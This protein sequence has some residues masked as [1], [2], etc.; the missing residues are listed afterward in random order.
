MEDEQKK[1]RPKS[2]SAKFAE[3]P[4][5]FVSLPNS[6]IVHRFWN[7]SLFN[8]VYLK[9]DL[10]ERYKEI[11]QV[12]YAPLQEFCQGFLNLC[13]AKESEDFTTWSETDTITNWVKPIMRLLGWQPD[14]NQNPFL[15]EVSFTVEERGEKKTYRLDILY[16]NDAKEKKYISGEKDPHKRLIEARHAGILP[17]EAKYWDRLEEYRQGKAESKKRIEHK[18]G[19]SLRALSPEGQ[20]LR[21]MQL[22]DKDYGILTDGRTW[23]LFHKNASDEQN[24]RC[25]EFNL[26]NL[27]SYIQNDIEDPNKLRTFIEAAKYFYFFFSKESLY[28]ARNEEPVVNEVLRYSQ[29]YIDHAEEDLRTRFIQAMNVACNGFARSAKEGGGTTDLSL[30]RSASESTLFNVLFLKHCEVRHV[31]PLRSVDYRKISL[32]TLIDRLDHLIFDPEKEDSINEEKLR[33]AFRSDFPYSNAGYEVYERLMDLAKVVHGGTGEGRDFGFKIEGFKQSIFTNEEWKFANKHKVPNGEMVRILFLLGFTE[34]RVR[35]RKYQQI[36]YAAFTPRQLGSIYESFLEFQ[37]YR[38]KENQALVNGEWQSSSPR[39][40]VPFVKKGDL[41]FS[42]E[43]TEKKATGSFYTPDN[44]VRLI[45]RESLDQKIKTLDSQSILKLKVCDPSMGSGHFLN[46]ALDYLSKAYMER[47]YRETSG[48]AEITPSQAKRLILERCVFGV[49]LN[50]RAVKLA[51]MALWLESALPGAGLPCLDTQ[52][53]CGDSLIDEPK[54]SDRPFKWEKQY[55]EV[56]NN[57]GFDLIVGNPPYGA[58]FSQATVAYLKSRYESLAVRAESYVLFVERG[59]K[60]LR[61]AGVI[62]YIIPDTYLNLG[63]TSNLRNFILKNSLLRKICLLPNDTFEDATVDVTILIT[64]RRFESDT[65]HQAK[66]QIIDCRD[67]NASDSYEVIENRRETPNDDWQQSDSFNVSTDSTDRLLLQK[68]EKAGEKLE[69]HGI[70]LSGIKTY[71]VGKG[72]PPQSKQIRDTKP[73]TAE[74]QMNKSFAPLY[75]GKH[76]GR[77]QNLWKSDCWVKYGEW[78]AAPRE[79]DNFEGEKI[80]IRKI[81]GETLIASYVSEK[82]YCNTLL[83]IA[84]LNETAPFSHKYLLAV[85]NSSLMG[86][87]FRKKFQISDE[88][89][90]PQIMIRD[91]LQFPIAIPSKEQEKAIIRHVD[92]I[93]TLGNAPD[94]LTGEGKELG[95]FTKL[96]DEIDALVFQV[97]GLTSQE[98]KQVKIP[99]RG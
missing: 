74:R 38:A 76:V 82:V 46:G 17:L 3:L 10:P 84:K 52:L 69:Q 55:P 47:L 70:M 59:V 35:N 2:R 18:D 12:D 72:T 86:W 45:L 15:E 25:F 60:L 95:S 11:W 83:F 26:G 53:R 29:Q 78:L 58:K 85:L 33:Q 41:Y 98:L 81:I 13:S 1:M 19:D 61:D 34:S 97:Y 90:F 67:H 77:Y 99:K 64:E 75:E 49:D 16:V 56:F 87:Y 20:I 93:L 66:V 4:K 94:K 28:P 65:Y 39:Q 51:K 22:L 42:A 24:K 96:S 21:Y 62:A 30:V 32:T 43:N 27:K 57:G 7:S 8:E 79:A 92:R 40:D 73:Y 54:A 31:L 23:R 68:L 80:L 88:D 37:L 6:E 36:P 44:V 71:E 91:I 63:F 9:V 89:T 50:P 48:N 5:Q 14:P